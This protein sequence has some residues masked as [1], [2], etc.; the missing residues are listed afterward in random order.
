M[1]EKYIITPCCNSALVSYDISGDLLICP[2]CKKSYEIRD[3]IDFAEWSSSTTQFYRW[4]DDGNCLVRFHFYNKTLDEIEG[5]TEKIK[6]LSPSEKNPVLLLPIFKGLHDCL[7]KKIQSHLISDRV[8]NLSII[9]K[10]QIEQDLPKPGNNLTKL[11]DL[12]SVAYPSEKT[13][14]E[15]MRDKSEVRALLWV[16]NKDE[17]IAISAWPFPSYV[18]T[19]KNRLPSESSNCFSILDITLAVRLN[20]FVI[21]AIKLI[22]DLDPDDVNQWHYEDL[23]KHRIQVTI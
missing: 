23:E 11:F 15:L 22:Y 10:A 7:R 13:K 20:S 4:A 17:H 14:I 19:D 3:D 12:L 16:R 6:M 21:D 18:H 1:S 8:P 5:V 2:D 9:Q